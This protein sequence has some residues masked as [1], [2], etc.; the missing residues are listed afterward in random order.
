MAM[1][2]DIRYTCTD[3]ACVKAGNGAAILGGAELVLGEALGQDLCHI[4]D[5]V[6]SALAQYVAPVCTRH[7]QPHNPC[8]GSEG[9]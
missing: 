8:S 5:R 9:R 3:L 2:A 1:Y 7:L 4:L 6:P